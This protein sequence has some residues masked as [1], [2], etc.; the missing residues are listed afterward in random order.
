MLRPKVAAKPL[1]KIGGPIF[2]EY[3]ECF[4]GQCGVVLTQRCIRRG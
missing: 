4:T 1:S 3:F 2:S